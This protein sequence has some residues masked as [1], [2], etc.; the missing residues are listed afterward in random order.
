[1]GKSCV[2]APSKMTKLFY[3]LKKNLG[4]NEAWNIYYLLN[5]DTFMGNNSF[6]LD[7][8]GVPTYKSILDNKSI[9]SILDENKLK[10]AIS[11][12][13]GT[14]E[15][16]D[17]NYDSMLE[18]AL[19]FNKTDKDF[20]AYVIRDK[21]KISVSL[22][23][24]TNDNITKVN[25]QFATN[26]LNHKLANILKDFGISI[27][28]LSDIE[29]NNGRVGVTDFSIARNLANDVVT[30]IKIAN[31]NEGVEA[32]S[33]EFSHLI[34]GAL[35][36]RPIIDRAINMLSNDENSL[37]QILGEKDYEDTYEFYDGNIKLIAEEALG[38]IL[39]NK[40]KSP[41]KLSLID[42]L[43][44]YIKSLFRKINPS[45]VGDAISESESLMN[46]LAKQIF[47]KSLNLTK[48]DI[49]N[50]QR[51]VQFNALSEK[52]QRNINN[53]KK[54][55][56]IE[57]K[58]YKI[59][60]SKE[61]KTKVI[62][63]Q[64]LT[65]SEEDVEL[66]LCTYASIA[67]KDITNK[68]NAFG[69][70]AKL[71]AKGRF[72]F[73][74]FVRTTL[75][76]Y[77][78]FIKAMNEAFIDDENDAENIFNK[79]FTIDKN[80][81]TIGD[82]LKDLTDL[83]NKLSRKYFKTVVPMFAEFIRPFVGDEITVEFGKKAGQKI[84]IK[85][86]IEKA[87]SDIGFID[88]WL[89]SMGNSSDIILQSFDAL[90]KQAHD[91]AKIKTIDDIKEIQ[92]LRLDAINLGITDW[93]WI[94]E[95]YDDGNLT[96]NIISK[97]NQAQYDKDY[98]DF[99]EYLNKKYGKNTKG[100]AMVDKT[101]EMERWHKTHS[102]NQL[103]AYEPNP[104]I[105]KNKDYENLDENH[106]KILERY[107]KLKSEID[108][109]LPS[110]KV[111]TLRA[112]QMRKDGLQRFIDST[113]S[114][115][116]IW[117]NIKEH[118]KDEF[119]EREDEVDEFGN[120]ISKSIT[121]FDGKE[122]M[123]L[124]L[125][126]TM[127]MKNPNDLTNDAIGALMAYT[128]MGNKYIYMNDIID[129][130]EVGRSII[131][132]GERKVTQ[133]RGNEQLKEKLNTLGIN[134]LTDVFIPTKSN[135]EAKL[136]DFFESQ[137]YG[138]YLKREGSFELFG[139]KLSKSKTANAFMRG[140]SI[141]MLGFNALA[142]LANVATG[143]AMQNIEAACGEYFKA[144]ELLEADAAYMKELPAY[145]AELNK[146]NKQSKLGLIDEFFNIKGE[147]FDNM[148]RNQRKGILSRAFGSLSTMAYLGQNCGDHWLYNRTLIAM[149]KNQKVKLED[150]SVKSL[151]D[152]I[153]IKNKFSDND[154][155]KELDFPKNLRDEKGN[156][157]D[158]NEFS[159]KV[160]G[161]NQNLFGIYNEED[162]NA[163]KRL[164]MG[165]AILQFRDWIR[166]QFKYR[167][168]AQRYNVMTKQWEEG[169]YRTF[170]RLIVECYQNRG[171]IIASW[172]KLST[173]E[174]KN[175]KRALTEIIQFFAVWGL[176][177]LIEW[178]D[179]K[180]RRPWH[181]RLIE[182]M[183]NREKHELGFLTP[184]PTFFNEALAQIKS[185][186]ATISS[187]QSIGSLLVSLMTPDD[188]T[189]ELQS[190]PYKGMS[191]VEKGF[192]KLPIFPFTI[193]RQ[194]NKI[195]D[196]DA[197]EQQIKYYSKPSSY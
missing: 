6:T 82:I 70:L 73:L 170:G 14:K 164:M 93:N 69:D 36:G 134:V 169:Y 116:S 48:Q 142:N 166:P 103:F 71:D 72:K 189:N 28:T 56:E 179:K 184:Q 88:R 20:V 68:Y 195:W 162:R 105:Y 126:Y 87:D 178:D 108:K 130:L 145:L 100:Q 119:I 1:M 24:K 175:I 171:N 52:A 59:T 85:D 8:E 117:A 60:D 154:E 50:N 42:R 21:D 144:K 23:P 174:R 135:I 79:T 76:S 45:F 128:A 75:Q 136:N 112:V 17:K 102:I 137:V 30:M 89:D 64:S 98:K 94:Y 132:D 183:L 165:R 104:A 152:V 155:I 191:N 149:L 16:T 188:Y 43:I 106:K 193:A 86:L 110:D 141:A 146:V 121:D 27:G 161:V 114:P 113:S 125:M 194:F 9:R 182:Y 168:G 172:D 173:K 81:L 5:S 11:N 99:R 83:S 187:C 96:G 127:K 44:N 150:D 3:Q 74:K 148:K 78:P 4:Y 66:G 176:C 151:W 157:F 65:T 34:V 25:E 160:L 39:Q 139:K 167:F 115:S 29:I 92:K 58:K 53:L 163:A 90:V 122:F 133:T 63:L 159:R 51:D 196:D 109:L 54:A 19:K 192:L 123:Q 181:M 97:I 107:I 177:N 32:L 131:T 129:G 35:K 180:K 153:E 57:A 2:Y 91:K 7:S 124:P 26:Q 13:F 41:V 101:L 186:S 80:E 156:T 55:I 95:K 22:L 143:V 47:D 37:R 190:G 18:E 120:P 140:S 46:N 77:A 138:K 40:L 10:N 111:N 61:Y 12:T 15:N 84:Q 118:L 31:N 49:I 67:L 62:N 38:H 33:E 147:F 197:L 158:I 185:P